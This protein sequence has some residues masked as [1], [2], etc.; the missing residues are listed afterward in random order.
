MNTTFLFHLNLI[1]K[2]KNHDVDPKVPITKVPCHGCGS[3]LQCA[4]SSLPGYLPSELIRGHDKAVLKVIYFKNQSAFN[5]KSLFS[6]SIVSAI[7]LPTMSLFED[8]QHGAEG[9]SVS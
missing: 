7:D 5:T 9:A 8:L 1:R 2:L 6:I 4:D 3:L